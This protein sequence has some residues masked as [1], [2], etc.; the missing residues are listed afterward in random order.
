MPPPAQLAQGDVPHRLNLSLPAS[1]DP[2]RR[3]SDDITG[4]ETVRNVPGAVEP[5]AAAHSLAQS[6]IDAWIDDDSATRRVDKGIVDDWF[7]R[8]GHS[9]ATALNKNPPK[10]ASL[11]AIVDDTLKGWQRSAEA[12]GRTGTP[13]EPSGPGQPLSPAPDFGGGSGALG[14]AG[15]F[16]I[17]TTT[18]GP[19][20]FA[21]IELSYDFSGAIKGSRL[22]SSSGDKV[23]NKHVLKVVALG[24]PAFPELPD[25]GFGIHAD[26]T[27]SVW[28]IDGH[29]TFERDVRSLDLKKDA[30]YLPLAAAGAVLGIGSGGFDETTGYVGYSDFRHPTLK[31]EAKLLQVY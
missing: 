22:L 29:L 1:S 18:G 23:F 7:A 25:G 5:G 24:L 20:L 13:G 19:G 30:W 26:G 16:H 14:Q 4:G 21:I 2:G 3:D 31:C 17:P 28:E 10:P 15:T 11:G 27:R 8:L 6:R 12:Y 9:L